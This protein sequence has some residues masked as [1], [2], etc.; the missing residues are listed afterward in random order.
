M[1]LLLIVVILQIAK[2]T[3]T[4]VAVLLLTI[5]V[6]GAAGSGPVTTWFLETLQPYHSQLKPEWK[7]SN[8]IIV[9][10][11]GQARWSK[12]FV[13]P[14]VF[15]IS[16]TTEAARLYFDCK[17]AGK[18]CTVITSGGD[19][20]T[21]GESEAVTM[22]T[23]LLQLGVAE[24]EILT[25]TESRNTFENAQFVFKAVAE[26]KFANYILV[27]SGF[28]M[29]RSELCFQMQG[30]TVVAAP[31]DRLQAHK[32]VYPHV[33]NFYFNNMVAHEYGGILKAYFLY[34]TGL[35]F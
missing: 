31:A 6:A 8:L 7:D 5:L 24:N 33:A 12:E 29:K 21:T 15:G 1:I 14:Q 4:S 35:R 34:T 26:Q 17:K 32:P 2:R 11:S 28:H 9:L 18:I 3:K 22:K 25:E 16:R 19:P 13:S 10:G 23:L 27:T 20:S 30:M